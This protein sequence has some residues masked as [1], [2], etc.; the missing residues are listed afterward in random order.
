MDTTAI[1]GCKHKSAAEAATATAVTPTKEST[2]VNI[3]TTTSTA[4]AVAGASLTAERSVCRFYQENR[5]R[6]GSDCINLHEGPVVGRGGRGE[7]EALHEDG[8]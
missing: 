2:A 1:T 8:G 6:F 7:E 4:E 5:C 3:A